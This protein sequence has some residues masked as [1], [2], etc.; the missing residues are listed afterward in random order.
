M[1]LHV[2]KP[3]DS[4]YSISR[5]YGV[6]LNKIIS[7][8]KITNPDR[9]VVGQVIVIVADAISHTVESGESLYSIAKNYGITL[10]DLKKAN[11]QIRSPYRLIP[12][13]VITV[14]LPAQKLGTI[15]VNGYA[16]VNIDQQILND[17]L[18][19]LTYLSPFSYQARPDGS[20]VPINDEPLITAARSASVAPIMVITNIEEGASFSSELAHTILNDP[21]IQS[22]YL[23]NVTQTLKAKNYYGLDI[24]FE[25]IFPEDREKYNDF[26][27]EVTQ[28]LN[29]MG[30][31][32]TTSLAPKYFANQ[33]GL[34]YEAHD[35]PAHGKLANHVIIMTYEWGYTYG[36]PMAVSPVNQMRRVLDYAVSVIPSEKILMGMPNYGYDWTLPY[37]R[38]SAARTISNSA[39]VNLAARVGAAIQYDTVA[40]A[41]FFYYYDESRKR[42]EVW[43]DDARS[44][45]AKLMLVHEY[46]LGGVSYW[47][48]NRFYPQ[49]WLVLNSMYDVRKVL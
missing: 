34:L 24:D 3:G 43:F 10:D 40:Q 4:I 29:P 15:D 36:P 20:I 13:M 30:Y 38:G 49:N 12:G 25:Y 45:Q 31:T 9:L 18:P 27:R 11:P 6:S 28:K 14:P 41:P 23:N 1:I 26:L 5:R 35:Y 46:N 42:H 16:M 32:V 33:Q 22:T 17:T 37:T 44:I 48:I 8:N 2:V 19:Y 7:D 39:A 21:Q 47:T